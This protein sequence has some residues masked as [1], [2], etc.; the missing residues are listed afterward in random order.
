LSDH[1]EN[2]RPE[3]LADFYA[4]SIGLIITTTA[5]ASVCKPDKPT[6]NALYMNALI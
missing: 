2:Y 4:T 1:L 3:S 6:G 5:F